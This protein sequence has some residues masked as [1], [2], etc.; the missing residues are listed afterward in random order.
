M[1]TALTARVQWLWFAL[2]VL[3]AGLAT[4]LAFAAPPAPAAAPHWAAVA[5]LLA[6]YLVWDWGWRFRWHHLLHRHTLG[7]GLLAWCGNLALCLALAG[8]APAYATLLWLLAGETYFFLHRPLAPF[9]MAFV[10]ALALWG[11]SGWRLTPPRTVAGWGTDILWLLVFAAWMVG[12]WM[13][14]RLFFERDR[15]R[16]LIAEL[17]ES[18]EQLRRAAAREREL[19]VL[20]ERERLARDLHDSVGHAL[21]LAAVK[22]EA[23]ERLARVDRER[24]A[25]ELAATRQLL[26]ETMAE[27]RR[28]VASLRAE[29]EGTASLA[30]EIAARAREVARQAGL[31]A[32]VAVAEVAGLDAAREEALRRVAQ[33]AL[34][35]VVKH[36]AASEVAVTLARQGGVV[37]L[38]IVDDGVGLGPAGAATDG[39]YGIR[40]MHERME[41]AGG[42]LTVGPAPGGGTRVYAEAPVAGAPATAPREEALRDAG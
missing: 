39:H 22:L 20:R 8:L 30:A 34:T 25:A 12:G 21:V 4:V 11:S 33:E 41:L 40:G 27:L 1:P 38:E 18:Q 42:R 31:R 29:P 16:R 26:R 14:D 19:T 9:G 2:V 23:T 10:L 15:N 6:A 3:F 28:A 17:R 5:P 36:A 35:N 24:A 13:V 32:H 7:W 37:A